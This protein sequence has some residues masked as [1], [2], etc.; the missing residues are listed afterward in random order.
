MAETPVQLM[1]AAYQSETGAKE[2]L[3][4]L[5]EAKKAKLIAIKDAAV[6]RKDAKGKVHITETADMSGG[7]GLAFG[8]VVG[9]AVGVVAGAA[10][11]GPVAIGALIGGLAAKLRDSGFDDQR[12]AKVG[13][14]LIPGS[15]AIVAVIEHKW[16][17]EIAGELAEAGAEVV[18][19]EVAQEIAAQLETGHDV[20]YSVLAT[21]QGMV[22][23]EEAGNEEESEGQVVVI[24]RDEAVGSRYVATPDGFAVQAIDVTDEGIVAD[25][26]AGLKRAGH[27][28]GRAATEAWQSSKSAAQGAAAKR[29][30]TDTGDDAGNNKS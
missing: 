14:G 23:W 18:T 2:A 13:D 30:K 12:L 10:L 4:E 24:G 7:K 28:A 21:D 25:Y 20:A 5:K 17:D 19:A 9:G 27:H 3:G 6:I 11:A 8:G 1:V 22:A 29:K 26:F 15:S 16:V